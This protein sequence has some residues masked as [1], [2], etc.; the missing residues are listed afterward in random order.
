MEVLH[1]DRSSLNISYG[2]SLASLAS[3]TGGS[4]R[5]PSSCCN[6]VGYKP[7]NGIFSRNG[8]VPYSSYLD[9]CSIIANYAED[10]KFIFN[11]LKNKNLDLLSNCKYI[12]FNFIKKKIFT[13]LNYKEFYSSK[14]IELLFNIIIKNL[15]KLNFNIINKNLN[16]NSFINFYNFLSSKEFYS[17]SCKYDGIKYGFFKKKYKNENDFIK[18]NRIFSQNCKNKIIKGLNILNIKNNIN[19]IDILNIKKFLNECFIDSNFLILPTNLKKFNLND[20]YYSEYIDLLTVFAN[21]FGFP[22][23]NIRMG[24][25]NHC[26]IGFQI[27]SNKNC[28]ID[29]LN[30]SILYE[31]YNFKNYVF[32]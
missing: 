4:V 17:N 15:E 22:S 25:L 26:P 11:I 12:N 29:L 30:I 24:L 13:I 8:M 9:N 23:I 3:D 5:T 28:D 10:C 6:I 16:L 32:N 20:N 7:T 19:N 31:S 14:E 2:C 27:F 18:L 21:V 1:Q